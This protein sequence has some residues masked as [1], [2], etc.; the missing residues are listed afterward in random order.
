MIEGLKT[1]KEQMDEIV[2]MMEKDRPY[3]E[4]IIQLEVIYSALSNTTS[5]LAQCYVK[6][7]MIESLQKGDKDKS[8][9]F[10]KKPIEILMR[11]SEHSSLLKQLQS[12]EA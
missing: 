10:I 4:I 1:I 12:I 8:F 11:V 9:E 6:S 7:S 2:R 3:E 5:A